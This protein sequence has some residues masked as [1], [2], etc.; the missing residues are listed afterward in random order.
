MWDRG[1]VEAMMN[2]LIPGDGYQECTKF[3]GLRK[4]GFCTIGI[5]FKQKFLDE[6]DLRIITLNL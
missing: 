3:Y 5:K 2:K 6:I 1:V 4:T